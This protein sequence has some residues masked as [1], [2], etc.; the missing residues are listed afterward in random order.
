MIR[1]IV[2]ATLIIFTGV[3]A[4]LFSYKDRLL[5]Q[6]SIVLKTSSADYPLDVELAKTNEEKSRG[7]M[8][9]DSLAE[10][11]GMLFINESPMVVSFWMKNMRFPIDMI[12]IGED[13]KVKE[14][15]HNAPPCPEAGVCSSYVSHEPIQYVLEVP[16][17]Y[18]KKYSISRG[19]ELLL[20]FDL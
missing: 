12:F 10:G 5:S 9:R 1:F 18:S 15:I 3:N 8:F 4:F 16:A 20:K 6:D 17:N 14:I 19:D 7:L 13:L 2:T 11:A